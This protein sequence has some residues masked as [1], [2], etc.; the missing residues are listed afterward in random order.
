MRGV[1]DDPGADDLLVASGVGVGQGFEF[2]PVGG[3]QGDLACAG[4]GYGRAFTR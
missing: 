2:S 4:D 3:G 1:A